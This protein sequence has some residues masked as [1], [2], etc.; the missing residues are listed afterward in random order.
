MR[1]KISQQKKYRRKKT[2]K[3]GILEG[4]K[5]VWLIRRLRYCLYLFLD[6]I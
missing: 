4:G 3:K 2:E 6:Y 1:C 5:Y